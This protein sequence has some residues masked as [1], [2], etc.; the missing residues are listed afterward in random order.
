VV[1]VTGPC[2]QL[3]LSKQACAINTEVGGFYRLLK[4][5]R[6]I[7]VS[8]TAGDALCCL[9][10]RSFYCSQLG[11]SLV[12]LCDWQW[13]CT[14]VGRGYRPFFLTRNIPFFCT[15]C[16]TRLDCFL[17]RR[18]VYHDRSGQPAV[19]PRDGHARVPWSGEAT[20]HSAG[21]AT[22]GGGAGGA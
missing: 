14:A 17:C 2:T 22:A 11:Q 20:D 9:R 4:L 7:S 8:C 6:P 16:G 15:A 10:R 21:Q 19:I 12:F 18:S 13:A 1:A 5:T 3:R